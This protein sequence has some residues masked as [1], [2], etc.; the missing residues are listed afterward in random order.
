MSDPTPGQTRAQ[1]HAQFFASR[2][3]APK[4][5]F[6]VD[7][8]SGRP[9]LFLVSADDGG[10]DEFASAVVYAVDE[11]DAIEIVR[12]EIAN[13]PKSETPGLWFPVAN[14]ASLR[15]VKVKRKR[16]PVL[17]HSVPG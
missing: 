6:E 4:D 10:Y 12:N 16:G 7:P 14:G 3:D 11:A 5:T 13:R 1:A 9:K 2:S 17:G 15:A 8:P